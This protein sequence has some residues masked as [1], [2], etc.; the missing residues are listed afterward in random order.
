MVGG[1]EP[2]RGTCGI[3]RNT[4]DAMLTVFYSAADRVSATEGGDSV[5]AH[6]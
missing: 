4:D 6:C 2:D 1:N 5:L 3:A